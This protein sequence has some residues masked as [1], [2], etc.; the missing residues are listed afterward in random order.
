MQWE[1]SQYHLS[2]SFLKWHININFTISLM[3]KKTKQHHYL[4][5]F[6]PKSKRPI[7]LCLST[8][9]LSY[10]ELYREYELNAPGLNCTL[11][12]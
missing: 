2:H 12:S 4:H 6:S 9:R 1:S 8:D 3:I 11:G 5:V 10:V 7:D